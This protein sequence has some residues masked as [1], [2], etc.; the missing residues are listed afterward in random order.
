VGQGRVGGVNYSG[1]NKTDIDTYRD[2]EVK[3]LTTTDVFLIE[4]E[5]ES[6]YYERYQRVMLLLPLADIKL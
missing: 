4:Q 5:T 2:R 3:A 6:Y 1:Y